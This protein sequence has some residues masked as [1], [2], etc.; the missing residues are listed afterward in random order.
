MPSTTPPISE[1]RTWLFDQALPFWAEAGVDRRHGGFVEELDKGGGVSD[2]AFKRV[3]VVCRQTY[4]F[5]HAAAL[6]W[7]P[8]RA[9]SDLGYAY[10]LERAW[11]G[12]DRGWARVLTREGAVLDP[13]PDLYDI[14]F[15]LFALAWRYR[16]TGDA[17]VLQWIDQSLDFIE[18]RLSAGEARGYWHTLPPSLP[19]LQNPHMHLLEALVEIAELTA[20]PDHRQRVD[21]I[22]ALFRD[23][24]FDGESLAEQFSRDWRRTQPQSLEPGHHFEWAWLLARYGALLGK[25]V[26][27]AVEALVRFGE[28]GVDARTGRVFD[29][30]T[31]DGQPE[32][33]TSRT[34]PNTE[35]IKGWLALFEVCGR[36]PREAVTQSTRVLLDQYLAAAGPGTWLDQIDAQGRPLKT[37]APASTFY[38]LF[39]AFTELLRLAPALQALEASD[40]R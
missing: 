31:A 38:H 34:W 27:S 20:N 6:G 11:L 39:L 29:S 15:V 35:R 14:A 12:S 5:S 33:R 2:T 7:A 13:T 8:G 4:V 18:R 37:Q 10:L 26:S 9:L 19:R 21:D 3:R 25:D 32:R 24:F 28:R 40:G 22:G 36:D 23:S 16:L 17:E 1:V 30:L